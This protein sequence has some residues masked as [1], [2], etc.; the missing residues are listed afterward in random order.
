[1][2][3]K[4]LSSQ[5]SPPLGQPVASV[6][7]PHNEAVD[8]DLRREIDRVEEI[9]LDS[10]RIPLTKRTLIDEDK[11]LS[12]LD[13]VRLNFPEAFEKAIEVLHHKQEI[14]QEAK[15]YAQDVVNSAHKRAAQILDEMELIRRAELEAG[16]IRRQVQHECEALQ[17]KTMT[18]VEQARRSAQQEIAQLR[19]KTLGECEEM[20]KSAD[21]YADSA[22]ERIE[23]QLSDM[24]KVIRNGRQQ[25]HHNSSRPV[26]KKPPS[27]RPRA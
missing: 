17:Q 22:L 8:F 24:L 6:P 7:P 1:M 18:E 3:S 19:Q 2:P 11:L 16:Q 4:K 15:D 10:F 23:H 25:L 27:V 14:I 20:Q 21:V 9:V 26:P 12:H 13:A 5:S